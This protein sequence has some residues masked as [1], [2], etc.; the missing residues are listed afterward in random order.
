[1][2]LHISGIENPRWKSTIAKPRPL[3]LANISLITMRMIAID[4]AWRIPVTIC[5]LAARSTSTRSR[6]RPGD[7]VAPAGVGQ[8]V[9]DGAH[10]LDGVEQDRP[11]RSRDD[12]EQL[13]RRADPEQQH[14]R[15]GPARAAGIAR[16]SSSAGSSSARSRGLAPSGDAEPDAERSPRRRSRSPGGRCWAATSVVS[17][18]D[19][20]VPN[21][22]RILR[23]GGR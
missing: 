19:Q 6:V 20:V 9:I 14:E 7:A 12:D 11:D 1:M 18:D 13:H 4:S 10:A 15:P 23:S 21:A 8:H 2:P 17:R 3:E 5:G 22:P 16:N